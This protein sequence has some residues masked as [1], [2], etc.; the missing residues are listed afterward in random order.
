MSDFH[1][2]ETGEMTCVDTWPRKK[3]PISPHVGI[4]DQFWPVCVGIFVGKSFKNS[5]RI[6]KSIDY[7]QYSRCHFATIRLHDVTEADKSLS[8]AAVRGEAGVAGER[9]LVCG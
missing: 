3:F 7:H 9:G 4:R 8:Q 6:V 5:Q 1:T 2:M